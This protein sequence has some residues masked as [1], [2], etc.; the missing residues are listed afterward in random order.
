MSDIDLGALSIRIK[1]C[2]GDKQSLEDWFE[3]ASRTACKNC[4]SYNSG[5]NCQPD[6]RLARCELCR[7]R[8]ITCSYRADYLYDCLGGELSV[9]RSTFG[10]ALVALKPRKPN[11]SARL[12]SK[13]PRSAL[14]SAPSVPEADAIVVDIDAELK[15]PHYHAP[16]LS[17]VP[18]S[19]ATLPAPDGVSGTGKNRECRGSADFVTTPASLTSGGT[20]QDGHQFAN[21]APPS[22]L[23]PG[24]SSDVIPTV[25]PMIALLRLQRR[26][27]ERL[28]AAISEE[29]VA[30]SESST[31]FKLRHTLQSAHKAHYLA[32]ELVYE[33]RVNLSAIETD[34]SDVRSIVQD[35]IPK[36]EQVLDGLIVDMERSL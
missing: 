18:A 1:D 8:K 3:V 35:C 34:S 10:R 33:T 32:M 17:P 13:A 11:T 4:T 21:F 16:D 24:L 19:I 22:S 25:H 23:S 20:D 30:Q 2:I 29:H 28:N 36:L 7:E 31:E 9:D 5:V 6:V 12:A 26:E 14:P 15:S 27:I